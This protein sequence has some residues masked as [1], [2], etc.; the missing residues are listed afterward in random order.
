MAEMLPVAWVVLRWSVRTDGLWLTYEDNTG[1]HVVPSRGWRRR[2]SFRP[3]DLPQAQAALLQRLLAGQSSGRRGPSLDHALQAGVYVAELLND[4]LVTL[5]GSLPDRTGPHATGPT[6]LPVL[7]QA[8][9]GLSA[10]PWE[11]LVGE[12]IGPM[13]DRDRIQIARIPI[14]PWRERTPF[15]LPLRILVLDAEAERVLQPLRDAGWYRDN[16]SVRSHGLVLRQRPDLSPRQTFLRE[17]YDVVIGHADAAEQALTTLSRGVPRGEHRPRLVIALEE[18]AQEEWSE[19]CPVP[20]PRDTSLLRVRTDGPGEGAFVAEFLFG[21]IH[22]HPLHEAVRSAMRRTEVGLPAPPR[23]WT[24]P[25]ANQSLRMQSS[26]EEFTREVQDMLAAAPPL[27]L[28]RVLTHSDKEMT[29]ATA[30]FLDELREQVRPMDEA[31]GRAQRLRWDFGQERWGLVPL[32]EAEDELE[33]VRAGIHGYRASLT[34]V[35]RSPLVARLIAERQERYVD[36]TLAD[37]N[38]R[39]EQGERRLATGGRYLLRVHVVAGRVEGGLLAE[40]PPSLDIV[41]EEFAATDGH[42]VEVAVFEKE[43]ILHS[44]RVQ[45]FFLPLAGSVAPVV[46]ELEAPS[47]PGVKELRVLLYH[48]NHVLQSFILRAEVGEALNRPEKGKLEVEMEFSRTEL[49]ADLDR[50]GPRALTIGVNQNGS[51]AQHAF[52]IKKD[53]AAEPVPFTDEVL[54]DQVDRYRKLLEEATYRAGTAGTEF[55]EARFSPYPAPGDEQREEFRDA[56]RQMA[57]LGNELYLSLTGRV[58]DDMAERLRMLR[59]ERDQTVQIIRHDA[60]LA[61]PWSILYDYPLPDPVAG[62]APLP[63]CVGRPID[64]LGA[65]DP[66]VLGCPHNPGQDVCC[67]DGF[68]GVRHRIEQ[69]VG[70]AAAA[71]PPAVMRPAGG[72]VSLAVGNPDGPAQRLAHELGRELGPALQPL[73]AEDDLLHLLWNPTSRPA[74]LIVLGHLQTQIRP[75]E[76]DRPRIAL[77][78]QKAGTPLP[79]GKWL[80]STVVAR[81]AAQQGRWRDQPRTIVLLMACSAAA[82]QVDTL[83]DF[84]VHLTSAGPAAVIGAECTVFSGLAARFAQEVT[85]DLWRGTRSLGGAVQAFNRTLITEGNPLAFAFA[86]YG[87]ADLTLDPTTL[88]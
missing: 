86:C 13:V 61:F 75:G 69:L 50:L 35:A 11:A 73:S 52:M 48:R 37:K 39:G 23:L 82:S 46:F 62:A 42:E 18:R 3:A 21:I 85:L 51:G 57:W 77:I 9:P 33:R 87:N 7:V 1:L 25:V 80:T 65:S 26:V 12:L 41:L 34:K 64:G 16:P 24:D 76:P 20:L 40:R 88:S 54:K 2:E 45:G 66:N 55:P 28:D 29:A 71:G 58:G 27:N 53:A 6:P 43:F 8:P 10:F 19:G 49:F 83:N 59:N 5:T 17:Q 30:P 70:T 22:D 63:V 84:V 81:K 78:P 79:H 74:V 38:G 31:L 60:N 67:V 72:G 36:L 44:P 32:A 47:T 56:V 14:R 4:R 68:W 15:R